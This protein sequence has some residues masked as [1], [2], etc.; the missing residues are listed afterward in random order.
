M[1]GGR[2]TTVRAE[3]AD[4]LG[5]AEEAEAAVKTSGDRVPHKSKHMQRVVRQRGHC[6]CQIRLRW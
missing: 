5:R 6:P 4:A 3:E 1:M 2:S